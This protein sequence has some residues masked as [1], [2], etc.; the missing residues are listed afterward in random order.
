M[1]SAL[2]EKSG[3]H[4]IK[5]YADEFPDEYLLRQ[6]LNG[7]ESESQDAFGTLVERHG[8]MVLGVCRHVLHGHHDAEDAFQATFLVLAR[9]AGSIRNGRVLAG[10]LHEVAHRIAIKARASAARRRTLERDGVAMSPAAIEPNNQDEAAAWKEL[11]PVL[12]AEVEMLPDRYRIPVILSYLEGKTNEEVA[13]LLR[14]PVG[15]VKGRLSRAR[16]L[17]RRRLLRRGLALSAAFLMTALSH[18]TVFAEV[19]PTD[20]VRRTV[21][22]A[23]KY[24][25]RTASSVPAGSEPPDLLEP[26]PPKPVA[27]TTKLKNGIV[28]VNRRM[29]GRLFVMIA[30]FLIASGIWMAVHG[31]GWS[32]GFRGVFS[33]VGSG[34]SSEF[35]AA[36]SKLVP[37]RAVEGAGC[38]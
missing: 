2:A 1:A 36:I 27:G 3:K 22:L 29:V 37:A 5:A 7:T 33:A 4:G 30:A 28:G 38:H 18:G 32:S 34:R 9:K 26:N 20:L 13:K 35:R 16:D 19:V 6:F 12:H 14:W 25:A 21:R 17:L 10:W 24:G 8:S 11:R 23:G 15:T 31:S